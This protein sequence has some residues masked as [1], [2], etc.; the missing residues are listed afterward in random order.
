VRR[1]L[2]DDEK[3]WSGSLSVVCRCFRLPGFLH[4]IRFR[5][6]NKHRFVGGFGDY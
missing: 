6:V 5:S 4:P 3:R 2:K 1:C